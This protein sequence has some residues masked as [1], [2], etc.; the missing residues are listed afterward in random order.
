MGLLKWSLCSG[1]RSWVDQDSTFSLPSFTIPPFTT[2]RLYSPINL[3]AL[4]IIS[5]TAFRRIRTYISNTLCA[6]YNTKVNAAHSQVT[7]CPKMK[8]T[9]PYSALFL[10]S[11]NGLLCFVCT[12]TASF[13]HLDKPTFTYF[14]YVLCFI[15]SIFLKKSL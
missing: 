15:K 12:S 7:Q 14:T 1:A 8:H 4:K 11:W 3:Y 10:C 6:R 2:H 13:C 5:V 9:F